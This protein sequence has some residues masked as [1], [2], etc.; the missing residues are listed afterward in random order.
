MVYPM[1]RHITY[2]DIQSFI[3]V[4]NSTTSKFI[5][6]DKHQLIKTIGIIAIANKIN[7]DNLLLN[8]EAMFISFM[9]L[10]NNFIC[11][12]PRHFKYLIF[13]YDTKFNEPINNLPPSLYYLQLCDSF[14]QCVDNLPI[15]LQYLIC[16]KQFNNSIDNLPN[17]I[18]CL[19]LCDDFNNT[20]DNLN[21]NIKILIIN[22][23]RFNK[24]INKL[25][26]NLEVFELSTYANCTLNYNLSNM[27]NLREI[28]LSQNVVIDLKRVTMHNNVKK[29]RCYIDCN[30]NIVNLPQN[31]EVL[32]VFINTNYDFDN[33]I[34]DFPNT[35]HTILFINTDT[36]FINNNNTFVNDIYFIIHI[37]TLQLKYPH[38]HITYK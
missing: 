2:Y 37:R 17:S 29:I 11:N 28:I 16:G 10:D 6:I 32:E 27:C 1:L 22:S 13:D 19:Y 14:N 8:Y 25:P 15:T 18:E 20:L 34:M 23:I 26:N 30:T 12:I 4:I 38:I 31:L 7:Y 35:L 5:N 24:D 33:N 3:S 21:D 9:Y 36:L